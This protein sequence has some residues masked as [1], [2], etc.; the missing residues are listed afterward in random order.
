MAITLLSGDVLKAC[1]KEYGGKGPI[2]MNVGR[3]DVI[4][5]ASL[6]AALDD[7]WISGAILDVFEIEPL[8]KESR[9]WEMSNVVISPHVSG[10][11]T[12]TAFPCNFGYSKSHF[13][14]FFTI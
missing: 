14:L 10:N 4:S 13:R 3:G 9:L 5:E 8:P 11:D 1:S 2:F 12:V 6:L 7:G